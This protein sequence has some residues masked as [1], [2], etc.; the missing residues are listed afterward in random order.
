M[1][2]LKAIGIVRRIDNLGRVVT[3]AGVAPERQ[4]LHIYSQ[5]FGLQDPERRTSESRY[6]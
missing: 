2:K 1:K 6:G 5:Y 3:A 4:R